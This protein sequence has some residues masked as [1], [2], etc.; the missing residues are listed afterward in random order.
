MENSL[1]SRGRLTQN[2]QP[3]EAVNLFIL[4]RRS[5]VLNPLCYI[6]Y[7]QHKTPISFPKFCLGSILDLHTAVTQ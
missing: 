4:V 1:E 6:I 5:V 3:D 7:K 2:L